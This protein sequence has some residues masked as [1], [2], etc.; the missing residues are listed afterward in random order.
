MGIK[1]ER[2]KRRKT[3]G[4]KVWSK[5]KSFRLVWQALVSEGAR[6]LGKRSVRD[7]PGQ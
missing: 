1:M 2:R 7:A 4:L 3:E 6:K 5:N